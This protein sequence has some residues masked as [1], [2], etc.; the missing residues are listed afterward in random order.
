MIQHIILYSYIGGCFSIFHSPTF[1]FPLLP[2]TDP[3]DRYNFVL[4]L[5]I[6]VNENV[7]VYIYVFIHTHIY[8]MYIYTY[9][10]I[11]MCAN[12]Y[13]HIHLTYRSWTCEGKRD[14]LFF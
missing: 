6:Y 1:S 14:L 4:S 11:C 10:I 9:Y 12:M 13:L 3:S 7:C 5:T 8:N 2:P